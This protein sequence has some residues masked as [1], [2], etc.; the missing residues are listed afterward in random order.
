MNSCIKTGANVFFPEYSVVVHG[1]LFKIGDCYLLQYRQDGF[2]TSGLRVA[3]FEEGGVEIYCDMYLGDSRFG[4]GYNHIPRGVAMVHKS[5][6]FLKRDA[7][8]Q[9]M[10]HQEGLQTDA[11]QAMEHGALAQ[12][13]LHQEKLKEAHPMSKELRLLVD[14]TLRRDDQWLR[15]STTKALLLAKEL[16]NMKAAETD[17]ALY[18]TAYIVDGVTIKPH[19]VSVVRPKAA[20]ISDGK[21][22]EILNKSDPRP[23]RDNDILGLTFAKAIIEE[24]KK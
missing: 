11:A 14:E 1:D 23:F 8:A 2:F 16:D 20:E 17:A 3:P 21:I 13:K 5:Q 19:R 12:A 7:L 24:L 18:G 22:I 4:E 10:A 15:I 9:A 6:V